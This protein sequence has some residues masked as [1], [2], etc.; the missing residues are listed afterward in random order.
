MSA[1]LIRRPRTHLALPALFA[2]NPSTAERV[3][4]FF[5]ANI[6]NP[7]TR[8]A[9]ARAAAT[10]ATWCDRHGI[11]ELGAVRPVHI[12]TYIEELQETLAA[13]SVKLQLA[14]IRMLFDWLVV[15]Q[16]GVPL[17]LVQ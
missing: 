12:A 10:F 16:I 3:L 2:P 13:P 1:A 9:Y 5:T 7:N 4:D 8:K 15:G 14:A 17:I 11:T 6:R